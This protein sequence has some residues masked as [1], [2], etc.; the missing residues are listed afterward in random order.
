MKVFTVLLQL[1]F[2]HCVHV[3]LVILCE[4]KIIKLNYLIKS[5]NASTVNNNKNSSNKE[6][7]NNIGTFILYKNQ[8][9]NTTINYL[10]EK[11]KFIDKIKKK[12]F[13]YFLFQLCYEENKQ[14]CI[15]TYVDQKQTNYM[16]DFV[17]ILGLNNNLLPYIL[18]Y[19]IYSHVNNNNNNSDQHI[20]N[21]NYNN[22]PDQPNSLSSLIIT[23]VPSVAI[24]IDIYSITEQD[25][26]N[27]QN[28]KEQKKQKQKQDTENEQVKEK[29]FIQKYWVYI[30][31][32]F[33]SLTISKHFTEGMQ[34]VGEAT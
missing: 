30:A 20:Y 9:L 27:K 31:I 28:T 1:L 25:N 22:N 21:S 32:F 2:L 18:N 5:Y 34:Q 17:L 13:D 7:W 29:S 24:P 11:K 19:R 12:N 6:E 10:E 15:Q 33:I 4:E 16:D 8:V 26:Q 14:I 23:K 3:C